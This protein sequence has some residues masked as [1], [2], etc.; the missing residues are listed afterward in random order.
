MD[1]QLPK[2]PEEYK[3]IRANL[4]FHIAED[5]VG[6]YAHQMVVQTLEN[7]VILSFFEVVPPFV[8]GSDED[9][10]KLA[11]AGIRA[12]CVARIIFAKNRLPAFV[13]AMHGVQEKL[14]LPPEPKEQT[15][16]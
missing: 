4:V 12:E 5:I 3:E 15:D 2:P 1:D 8:L 11:A 13:K 14:G 9:Q 10:E 7:E 16:A 6:K